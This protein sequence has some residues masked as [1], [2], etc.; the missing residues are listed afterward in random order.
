MKEGLAEMIFSEHLQNS[1]AL[2]YAYILCL[3]ATYMDR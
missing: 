2:F 3:D 1:S